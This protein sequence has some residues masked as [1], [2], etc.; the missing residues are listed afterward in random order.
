MRR[1]ETIIKRIQELSAQDGG[2][3]EKNAE[4]RGGI[5]ELE[6]AVFCSKGLKDVRSCYRKNYGESSDC[7]SCDDRHT[8][9]PSQKK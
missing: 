3:E 7:R 1:K 6:W 9:R 8:C 2:N 4:I 5:L